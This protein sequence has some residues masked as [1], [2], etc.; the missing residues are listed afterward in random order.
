[1]EVL[2]VCLA[3]VYLSILF[4]P[5]FGGLFALFNYHKCPFGVIVIYFIFAALSPM[6]VRNVYSQD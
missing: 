2:T 5:G 4:L 6:L 1:M 3:A